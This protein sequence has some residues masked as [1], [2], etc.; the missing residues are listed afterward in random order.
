MMFYFPE[1]K[2]FCQSEDLTHTL[3]NLYTL[4]GAQVRNGQKWSAYI[5]L[6][7]AKWGDDVEFSFASHL[8]NLG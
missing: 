2:A 3:H 5:D 4:R 8:A 1:L 7:L 6:A